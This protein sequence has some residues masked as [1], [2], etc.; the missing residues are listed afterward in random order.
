MELQIMLPLCS[1]LCPCWLQQCFCCIMA[2]SQCWGMD[3]FTVPSSNLLRSSA[4]G[5]VALSLHI[6][7]WAQRCCLW[8]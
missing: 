2:G 5:K 8:L 7:W 4:K 3:G 1:L 6:G